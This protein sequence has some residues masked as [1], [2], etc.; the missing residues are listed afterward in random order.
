MLVYELASC[1]NGL[2]SEKNKLSS[3]RW[4]GFYG[5]CAATVCCRIVHRFHNL[6]SYWYSLEKCLNF[7]VS[8][9]YQG[10]LTI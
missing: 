3:C 2:T 9:S 7:G 1:V 5:V 8:G 4:V 10:R 6:V